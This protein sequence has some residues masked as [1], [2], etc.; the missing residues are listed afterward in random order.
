[1]GSRKTFSNSVQSFLGIVQAYNTLG[2]TDIVTYG[3][4]PDLSTPRKPNT[5]SLRLFQ[6]VYDSSAIRIVQDT[7]VNSFLRGLSDIGG[8]YTTA[9]AIFLFVFG[10]GLAQILGIDRFSLLRGNKRREE[11]TEQVTEKQE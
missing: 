7:P 4:D 6:Q 1:M 5:S 3:D 8:L 10:F 2:V 11:S 9:S